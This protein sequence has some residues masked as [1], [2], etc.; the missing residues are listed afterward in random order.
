MHMYPPILNL[1]LNFPF[2]VS[3]PLYIR[4]PHLDRLHIRLVTSCAILPPSPHFPIGLEDA[5]GQ[6]SN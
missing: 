2:L 5:G 3:L 4:Y 6:V 1:S